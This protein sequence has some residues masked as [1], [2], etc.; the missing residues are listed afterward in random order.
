MLC[1]PITAVVRTSEVSLQAE[2]K[3][4]DGERSIAMPTKGK[5][6]YRF[7]GREE[8]TQLFADHVV[9]RKLGTFTGEIMN[10]PPETLLKMW[11]VKATNRTFFA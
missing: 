6:A 10:N 3:R 5:K 2:A 8:F 4:W 9:D 1:L 7:C 11:P